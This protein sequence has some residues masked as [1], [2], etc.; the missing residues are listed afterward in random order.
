LTVEG[1]RKLD[2]AT[3][4]EG[5][6]ELQQSSQYTGIT[7]QEAGRIVDLN[8]ERNGRFVVRFSVLR[9]PPA[10]PLISTCVLE[11]TVPQFGGVRWW[12]RCAE[13]ERRC[14]IIYCSPEGYRFGCRACLRLSYQ[15]NV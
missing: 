6:A 12:F 1:C 13:C 5:I 9:Q 4:K 10:L 7:W 3:L 11:S 2:V 8:R 15:S 14:R